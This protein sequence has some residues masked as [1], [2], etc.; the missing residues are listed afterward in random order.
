MLSFVVQT[1]VLLVGAFVL[2]CAAGCWA[3][4]RRLGHAADLR[5][6]RETTENAPRDTAAERT[7]ETGGPRSSGREPGE[8][9]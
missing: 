2:G 9:S 8:N 4:R 5:A 1:V 3:R 6:D 7:E